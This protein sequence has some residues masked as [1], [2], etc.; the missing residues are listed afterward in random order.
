MTRPLLLI[1]LHRGELAFGD[2][3]AARL[4][5]R[6]E[7]LRIEQGLDGARPTADALFLYRIR[8]AEMYRQVLQRLG[9]RR[10]LVLDLHSGI[11]EQRRQAEVYCRSEALLSRLEGALA[12]R[13]GPLA[14]R[15]SLLRIEPESGG[16]AGGRGRYGVART[17]IPED[18][19]RHASFCYVGI[20]VFLA[21]AGAGVA[22]DH[23]FAAELVTLI[24]DCFETAA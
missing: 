20:E 1:G 14:G 6:V 4:A 7:L 23:A 10:G 24:A 13:G 16:A 18:V 2:Q 5:G 9:H 8:H 11:D 12:R 3:V 21:A 19:W 17:Y 22:E 15:V